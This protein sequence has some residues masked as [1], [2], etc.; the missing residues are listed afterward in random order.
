M[1]APNEPVAGQSK[2]F[3]RFVELQQQ[4]RTVDTLVHDDA[5]PV[6][7]LDRQSR[8]KLQL[9]RIDYLTNFALGAVLVLLGWATFQYFNH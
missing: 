1:I 6:G 3:A 7:D 2:D 5:T 4:H 8:R 9:Q